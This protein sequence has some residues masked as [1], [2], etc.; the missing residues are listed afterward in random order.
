MI[1]DVN[2]RRKMLI[3]SRHLFHMG[4]RRLLELTYDVIQRHISTRGGGWGGG[5]VGGSSV[6][7]VIQ[8][9]QKVQGDTH[10]P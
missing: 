8:C 5:G 1:V 3:I 2:E 6:N 9:P 4:I 7:D 10:L